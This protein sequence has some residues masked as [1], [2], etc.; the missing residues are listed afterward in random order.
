MKRLLITGSSGMLGGNLAAELKDK[1]DII[2]LYRSHPNPTI[3]SQFKADLAQ[4]SDKT[5]ALITKIR[6]D[7]VI[8]C[9]ALTNV[10][11]CEEDYKFA[12][13]TNA[14]AT[15]NLIEDLAPAARFIYI[16]TDSVFDGEKG[17]YNEM[18]R[19]RPL[20]NYAKTKLEGE[21]FVEGLSKN[22]VII[23]TN[24]FGWNRVK[25]VSFA[26]WVFNSLNQKK[27]INM[28]TDVIFSPIT[29]GTLSSLI[30][31][32][33]HQNFT[34][35]LNVGS[36]S[37]IS[38]YD[39]GTKIAALFNFDRSL[40]MPT[41]VDDFKFKAKRPKNTSLNVSK[42]ETLLGPLPGVEEELERFY[43]KKET[44]SEAVR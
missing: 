21:L 1:C 5:R 36:A 37:S 29:A 34:G 4:Y 25:G 20:N 11:A 13:A 41:S 23:R 44:H 12:Y 7:A 24:I 43:Q 33:L 22:H 32:L 9:A 6:P 18:D 17:D 15:R 19:P 26:E 8:H 40:I 39:F 35:R 42:A 3:V 2:G 10:E 38:K 30:N 16:S 28:F 27:K 31:K 14:A